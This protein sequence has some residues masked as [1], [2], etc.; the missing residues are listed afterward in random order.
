MSPVVSRMQPPVVSP[1][2]GRGLAAA[3]RAGLAAGRDGDAGADAGPP[4]ALAAALRA[5][6]HADAAVLTDSGTSALVLALRLAVPPGGTVALPG[7]GCIDLSA[8]CELAGVR[9]RL[10]DLD[11][12]TLSPDLDSLRAT[13]GRG[14]DAV[15]VAH[16]YGYPADVPA[17]AALAAAHGVPVIEDAAQAAAGVLGERR[18][19]GFGTYTVLSFG[20]GKGTTGGGGGALLARGAAAARAEGA[21]APLA[22]APASEGWKRVGIVAAQ[23]ALG[24]PSLYWLPSAMPQLRLG[25]MVYHPAEEPSRLPLP[26]AALALDSLR[27][28]DGEAAGRARVAARL[29]GDVPIAGAV[30][31][32]A[33]ARPGYLRLAHRRAGGPPAPALGIYLAYPQT[34]AEHP[35]LAPLL[36]A[37]EHAGAGSVELRDTLYTLPTHHFVTPRD[38]PRLTAWMRGAAPR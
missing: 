5:R 15:V 31:P 27:R 25:Q 18:I 38:V 11:P 24:R 36:H 37:G 1:V 33:G 4:A 12:A 17:V 3:L 22:P 7:F 21:A 13:L 26:S 16:F 10:Y 34:L 19:G 20:R 35:P 30:T 6:F 14:V 28:A 32:I 2:S 9:A 8:A 23:W 29:L